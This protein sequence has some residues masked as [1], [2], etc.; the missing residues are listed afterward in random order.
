MNFLST[1]AVSSAG[2]QVER[3]R[4]DVAAI[5]IA[6]AHTSRGLDGSVYKPLIANVKEKRTFS[7]VYNNHAPL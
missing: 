6:N 2:M 1:I 5:N 3:A 7:S 4:L